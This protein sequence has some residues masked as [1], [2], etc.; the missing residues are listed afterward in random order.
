MTTPDVSVVVV[1]YRLLDETQ[2]CLCS[3]RAAAPGLSLE[4]FVVDNSPRQEASGS[5]LAS[6][7]TVIPMGRNAGLAKATNAALRRASG[8]YR[9]C[10]NPDVVAK[11]GSIAALV[12][13]AERHPKAGIVAARLE[14]VDGSLQLSCRRFYTL[15]HALARRTP[16]RFVLD[17]EAI[18]RDHLMMDYDHRVPANVDWVLGSC[19][20]VRAEA[21]DEVG[22]MDERYF[23]YFEDVDWCYRMHQ[24]GWDVVYY[25][26]ASMVHHHKR[27]SALPGLSRQK[28]SHLRS[29]LVF[30]TI[31]GWHLLL[32]PPST[33]RLLPHLA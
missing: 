10:L 8:R 3:L 16:L 29:F 13:C 28:W 1:H 4:V 20:L 32:R 7:A 11:P 24:H 25:P 15:A 5:P 23:L 6:M 9:L 27:E 17:T 30:H 19:L 2:R 31:H 22:A 18:N 26:Y 12:S 21:Q 33:F 14:N